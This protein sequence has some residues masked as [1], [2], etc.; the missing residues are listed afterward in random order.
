[1]KPQA[2]NPAA[3]RRALRSFQKT[4]DRCLGL[5]FSALHLG[6][7]PAA[8]RRNPLGYLADQTRKAA[9]C[10]ADL[11]RLGGDPDGMYRFVGRHHELAV[12]GAHPVWTEW[13]KLPTDVRRS[14]ESLTSQE[15]VRRRLEDVL[16]EIIV[17]VRH[18]EPERGLPGAPFDS[19]LGGYLSHWPGLLEKIALWEVQS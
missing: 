13:A 3:Q 4:Y 15:R 12:L 2:D 19:H 18:S 5:V 7:E 9:Q 10:A 16:A 14:V 11:C 6:W 17:C 1:M 8:W